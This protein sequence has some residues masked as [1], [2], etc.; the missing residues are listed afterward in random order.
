MHDSSHHEE[1]RY[2][3]GSSIG[4]SVPCDGPAG[5]Q[6]R[7]IRCSDL[8]RVLKS[9]AHNSE[10]VQPIHHHI[11][12]QRV[13]K[14]TTQISCILPELWSDLTA[15]RPHSLFSIHLVRTI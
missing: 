3:G 10:T 4:G 2:I 1:L 9:E 15:E 8:R 14:K 5:V 11:S 7:E 13:K 6:G 12:E